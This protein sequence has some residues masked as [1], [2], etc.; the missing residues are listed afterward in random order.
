MLCNRRFLVLK[1]WILLNK[2]DISRARAEKV[3]KQQCYKIR[4]SKSSVLSWLTS[5]KK[6]QYPLGGRY[7]RR[8]VGE[9]AGCGQSMV[10]GILPSSAA[11]GPLYTP[12]SRRRAAAPIP[13]TFPSSFFSSSHLSSSPLCSLS[14]H[15]CSGLVHNRALC[16]LHSALCTL[17]F[18]LCTLHSTLYT[19]LKLGEMKNMFISKNFK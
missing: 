6:R 12:A 2:F 17:H 8:V 10:C 1:L 14:S 19:V 18:A 13:L 9:P 5:A 3:E 7:M 4:V 11:C 16:T 15:V